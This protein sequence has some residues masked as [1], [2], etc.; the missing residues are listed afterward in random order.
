MRKA[1][2][3]REE[4]REDKASDAG[5]T[6]NKEHLDTQIR[7]FHS[8]DTCRGGIDKV[9]CGVADAKVPQPVTSDGKRHALSTNTKGLGSIRQHEMTQWTEKTHEKLSCKYPNNR[10]PRGGEKGDIAVKKEVQ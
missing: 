8:I 9:G 1:E 4:L 2:F 3:Q 10:T 6:P 5:R 7:C